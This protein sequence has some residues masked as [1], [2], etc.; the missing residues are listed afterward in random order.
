[1]EGNSILVFQC[2]DWKNLQEYISDIL[3]DECLSSDGIFITT[4]IKLDRH[5]GNKKFILQFFSE[6]LYCAFP[7]VAEDI[8]QMLEECYSFLH[9]AGQIDLRFRSAIIFQ[10]KIVIQFHNGRF[11]NFVN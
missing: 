6:A 5:S 11:P 10:D 4:E 3:I 1:M 9:D 7:F 8:E 2:E